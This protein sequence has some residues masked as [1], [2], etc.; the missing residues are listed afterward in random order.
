MNNLRATNYL[1]PLNRHSSEHLIIAQ[2]GNTYSIDDEVPWGAK[3][4]ILR[5]LGGR[6][7]QIVGIETAAPVLLDIEPPILSLIKP[8]SLSTVGDTFVGSRYPVNPLT[9]AIY[10]FLPDSML[11][12]MGNPADCWRLISI[13]LWLDNLKASRVLFHRTA[14]QAP[15]YLGTIVFRS[16]TRPQGRSRMHSNGVDL[17][18]LSLA[19]YGGSSG[20]SDAET[21]AAHLLDMKASELVEMLY[22]LCGNPS[23]RSA[24][25]IGLVVREL[26]AAREGVF[27]NF[28]QKLREM[29]LRV[30]AALNARKWPGQEQSSLDMTKAF[31]QRLG[32]TA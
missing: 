25:I 17:P 26:M 27:I 20:W 4:A 31:D 16:E 22:E 28:S 29:Q 5:A 12:K 30:D 32:A 11:W 3:S 15:L 7:C 10:D 19:H 13:D 8:D 6:L 21:A 18:I 24:P 23:E 1:R 9:T 2:D 14:A